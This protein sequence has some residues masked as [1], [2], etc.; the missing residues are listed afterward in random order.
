MTSGRIIML[1]GASSSGKTTLARQLQTDLE[2][3]FLHFS[4]DQ[5]VDGGALPRRRDPVGAF[6]WVGQMRPRFFDGFHR[7]IPALA[8]AGNNLIVD[9]IIEYRPWRDQLGALL[10]D[11]DVFLVGV[12]CDMDELERREQQRG[13][14]QTG[15]GRSHIE[16]HRIHD[17]GPYDLSVDTTTGN[18]ESIARVIIAAWRKRTRQ[19]GLPPSP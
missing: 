14:R 18:I 11:F 5:L 19:Q 8:A 3:P 12:H 1:N 15:E 2:I 4:S 9:H 6:A 17:F 13:D 10:S 7:C 16:D